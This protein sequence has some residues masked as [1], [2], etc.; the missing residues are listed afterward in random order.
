MTNSV[1]QHQTCPKS[2]KGSD[3]HLKSE[4]IST[5]LILTTRKS[6]VI[7]SLTYKLSDFEV[8]EHFHFLTSPDRTVGRRKNLRDSPHAKLL[9]HTLRPREKEVLLWA[10][11]GKTSWETA[12]LLDL[13]EKTIKFYL[14]NA[15]KRL[16]VQNKTHAV[17]LCLSEG[18]FK[19]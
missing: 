10:A 2:V 3:R 4:P 16:A 11:R 13:S 17:A 6:S 8:E 5:T 9:S 1:D 19:L 7:S 12:K 14:S 15:R 18:A